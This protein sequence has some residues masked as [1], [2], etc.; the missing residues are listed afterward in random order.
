MSTNQIKSVFNMTP[1]E[2]MTD[3]ND[4]HKED[5]FKLLL[6]D[7]IYRDVNTSLH[8]NH[9]D[10]D[11]EDDEREALIEAVVNEC[12]YNDKYDTSV[13]HW[14]NINNLINAELANG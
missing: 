11:L 14:D 10:L 1:C 12:V 2:I 7:Y 3:M 8:E 6:S 5:L 9:P 4:S 13:S